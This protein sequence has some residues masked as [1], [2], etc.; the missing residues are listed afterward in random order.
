MIA[1]L[2]CYSFMMR[3]STLFD[4]FQR[5]LGLIL[6]V[7]LLVLLPLLPAR[8]VLQPLWPSPV[9]EW[10]ILSSQ[11]ANTERLFLPASQLPD[12]A[13]PTVS[14]DRS[15]SILAVETRTGQLLFGFPTVLSRPLAAVGDE[16]E[17]DADEAELIL[18]PRFDRLGG[19]RVEMGEDI[20]ILLGSADDLIELPVSELRLSYWP[21][22]LSL[23]D[24]LRITVMRLGMRW[25]QM[26]TDETP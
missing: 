5:L 1:S 7:A 21:N 16:P 13:L 22:R 2:A 25:R 18:L 3:A 20:L 10:L 17:N 6:L 9:D 14:R 8:H 19:L 4:W 26:L 23:P 15:W 12:P 11:R 24:R